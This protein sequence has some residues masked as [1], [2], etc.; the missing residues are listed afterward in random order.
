V[1]IRITQAPHGVVDGIDLTRFVRGLTYDVGT[2]LGN[3]LLA[4]GWAEPIDG[5]ATTQ[6]EPALVLPLSQQRVLVVEDDDDFR[7][8]VSETLEGE[9]VTVVEARNGREG[10]SALARYRPAVIVL[11]LQMPGMDGREFCEVQHRLTDPELSH[12]PIVIVSGVEDA[13]AAGRELGAAETLSKPVDFSR[14]V[15]TIRRHLKPR[16]SSR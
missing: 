12:V 5:G 7:K 3:L 2:A 4:E 8:L 11:D 10:L 1:R 15:Q 13:N 14:L 6:T 16:S 9:G